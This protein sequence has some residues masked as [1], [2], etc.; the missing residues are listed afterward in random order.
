MAN[1]GIKFTSTNESIASLDVA[2][3]KQVLPLNEFVFTQLAVAVA[4]ELP[5]DFFRSFLRRRRIASNALANDLQQFL[6]IEKSV[7]G[8]VPPA[9]TSRNFFDTRRRKTYMSKRNDRRASKSVTRLVK[10]T[11]AKNSLKSIDPS[12]FTSI[13]S[14]RRVASSCSGNFDAYSTNCDLFS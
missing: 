7:T 10:M 12:R 8:L 6:L 3:A 5:D 14:N 11:I 9:A 13:R 1:D 2:K 4:I